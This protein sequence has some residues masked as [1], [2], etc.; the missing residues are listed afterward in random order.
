VAQTRSSYR[1]RNRILARL[2]ARD[3]E[4][5][6]PLLEHMTLSFKER[7]YDQDG[8]IDYVYFVEAGMVSLV[9]VLDEGGLIETGTV[10]REGM[11]GISA[12]FGIFRS[13]GRAFCQIP[14][15][16]LRMRV[17]AFNAERDRQT[18]LAKWVWRYAHGMLAMLAQTAACNRAHSLEER[19][20]RWLLL[21]QDRVG[22]ET[23]PLTQEFLSQM[24]GVRRP[25]VNLAGSTLQKAG[26][27]QY[28]RG[29][30]TVTN[31]RGLEDASC[32]CYAAIKKAFDQVFEDDR[33]VRSLGA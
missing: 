8:R 15:A 30:I 26:L 13:P 23:F 9:A 17:E 16:V 27:I 2:P 20:A 19:L 18:E 24:L 11:V 25:T 21:T 22:S 31:R 14:G 12:A 4:R 6:A 1:F 28:T 32:E 5:I 33:A 3:Q 29:K 7:L 10:G